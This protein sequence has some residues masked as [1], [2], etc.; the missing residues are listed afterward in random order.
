MTATSLAVALL[1]GIL[2]AIVVSGIGYLIVRWR[3]R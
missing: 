2:F 1:A 3:Y